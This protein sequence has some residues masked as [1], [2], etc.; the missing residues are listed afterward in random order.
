MP[1]IGLIGGLYA[2]WKVRRSP[3]Q[4]RAWAGALAVSTSALALLIWQV[5]A[6]PVAQALAAPGAAVVGWSLLPHVQRWKYLLPRVLGIGALFLISSGLIVQFTL[7]II[8]NSHAETQRNAQLKGVGRANA[9]CPTLPALASIEALPATTVL[10][11]VDLGPRLINTTHHSAIAGPYHRNQ[12][13]LLDVIHA[14]RGTADTAHEVIR[15][16]RVGMVLICPG[17][18]EST[19]Y[20]VEAPKG[21]YVQ[22]VRGKVPSW[23]TPIPLPSYSPFRAWR[24]T[25]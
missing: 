18:S 14:W 11:F 2:L 22:L 12:A 5:R 15:R 25:G 17:M 21:F 4:L 20:N 13:A 1:V 16:H 23:L 24:V 7:Q 9:R 8:P 10:T 3:E 19:I 6:G